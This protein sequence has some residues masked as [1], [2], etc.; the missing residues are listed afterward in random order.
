MS[1]SSGNSNLV[2]F[3][4]RTP[5]KGILNI[6]IKGRL[7]SDTTTELWRKSK[8]AV[9]KYSPNTLIV[10]GSGITYCDVA[11]IAL[12]LQLRTQLEE[13]GGRFEIQGLAKE[14]QQLLGLFPPEE[15]RPHEIEKPEPVNI[16][17]EI[18]KAT[19]NVV[20]YIN[21]LVYFIGEL[22]VSLFYSILN[23]RTI[24]WKD[25]F[26]VAEKVG[27]N[28][29]GIIALV[30]FLIGL[31]LAFQ[32]AIPLQKYG[33][34]I[35]VAD[36][37]SLSVFREIG[38]L[39]SAIVING[40][41]SSAFAAELGTM[42]VNE[43]ID[44]LTTMGLEPV[45][46]L[47]IPKVIAALVMIPLLTVFGDLFGIIGGG[48]VMLSLG[49]PIVT[50]V[51]QMTLAASYVDILGGLFKT[52]FFALIISGVGCMEG[53]RTKTGASAVGDSTT[54]AVVSGLI[55]II[56]VDGIFGVL[57]YYLGI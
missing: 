30:N 7:D 15:F 42:K 25:V 20:E 49:Y 18:G 51:N 5:E 27:V 12:F 1:Q 55:L 52:I 43:E 41:T 14:F 31:V 29:F 11:G 40:R 46:F 8:I 23:P 39:M 56:L 21:L 17:E 3:S 47:V 32:S 9:S 53:L 16:P 4:A 24:R 10:D 48:V 19:L 36:L 22:V 28:A 37:I 33:G 45:R 6:E 35:F 57:Y 38:P 54:S 50:Y 13:L 34:A 2:S 26:V 44:A